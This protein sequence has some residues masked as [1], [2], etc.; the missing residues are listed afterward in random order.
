MSRSLLCPA[1][2]R[3]QADHLVFGKW[4]IK[5]PLGTC[6][7]PAFSFCGAVLC[8]LRTSPHLGTCQGP[9]PPC[10]TCL[11]LTLTLG[12]SRWELSVAAFL[13]KLRLSHLL[14][15]V[16]WGAWLWRAWVGRAP[17]LWGSPQ[18]A[19][20]PGRLGSSEPAVGAHPCRS[21]VLQGQVAETTVPR[22][23]WVAENKKDTISYSRWARRS[24][25]QTS[26]DL[27]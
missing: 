10:S 11:L 13:T 26:P 21:T 15:R 3:A 12:N 9:R 16:G 6:W 2:T 18:A 19:P 17:G 20:A 14:P 24:G 7:T 27:P 22:D 25:S 5:S 23:S 1:P 4:P 8:I